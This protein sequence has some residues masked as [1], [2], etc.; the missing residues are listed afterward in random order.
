MI[1]TPSW[2]LSLSKDLNKSDVVQLLLLLISS[3]ILSFF[4]L[5]IKPKTLKVLETLEPSI[6]RSYIAF[7]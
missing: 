7:S 1:S 5:F 2:L 6:D 4:D 3:S